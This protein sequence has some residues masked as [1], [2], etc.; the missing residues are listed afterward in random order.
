MRLSAGGYTGT[1]PELLEL[2]MN[3]ENVA[4]SAACVRFTASFNAAHWER[5]KQERLRLGLPT[6]VG[7]VARHP[8]IGRLFARRDLTPTGPAT[9]LLH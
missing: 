4:P 8:F 7:A 3:H 6:G 5:V 1:D 2:V 9:T